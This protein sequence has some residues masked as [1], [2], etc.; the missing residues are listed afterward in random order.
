LLQEYFV[1]LYYPVGW[2]E[3]AS[4]RW[5]SEKFRCLTPTKYAN[6]GVVV[7]TLVSHWI[8]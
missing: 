2:N 3:I 5:L 7:Q 6:G 4:K 8:S 1:T